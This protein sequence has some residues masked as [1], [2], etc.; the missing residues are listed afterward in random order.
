M[1]RKGRGEPEALSSES[2]LGP[3]HAVAVSHPLLPLRCHLSWSYGTFSFLLNTGGFSPFFT[4]TRV[5][6][7]GRS[8]SGWLRTF[9]HVLLFDVCFTYPLTC[10]SLLLLLLLLL[11]LFLRKCPQNVSETLISRV[12][13]SR[14]LFHQRKGRWLFSFGA[15]NVVYHHLLLYVRN[16]VVSV[17]G[18][19]C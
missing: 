11:L 1:L 17:V 12:G 13:A 3:A 9:Q 14:C 7:N 4:Y 10:L 5:T 6:S 18:G 15:G 16:W 8:R 19:C 2:E